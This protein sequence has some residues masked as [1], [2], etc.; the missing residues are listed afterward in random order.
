MARP[1]TSRLMAPGVTVP[2]ENAWAQADGLEV[3]LS[4]VSTY[5]VAVQVVSEVSAKEPFKLA[6]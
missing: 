1:L 3:P 2:S 5:T 4:V 6:P